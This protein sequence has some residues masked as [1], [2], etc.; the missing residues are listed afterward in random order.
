MKKI[1]LA[2]FGLCLFSLLATSC[3]KDEA[4]PQFELT[5]L[6]GVWEQIGGD[7]FV[8]CSVGNNMLIEI[9]GTEIQFGFVDDIGCSIAGGVGF[10]Y[11]FKNGNTLSNEMFQFKVTSLSDGRMKADYIFYGST[12]KYELQKLQ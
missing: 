3:K 7:D 4:E 2:L 11:E 1:T 12:T 5:D 8:S 9:T 6:I 10:E